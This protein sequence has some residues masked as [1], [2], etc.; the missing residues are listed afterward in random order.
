MGQYP[1]V[2]ECRPDI[3]AI[4]DAKDELTGFSRFQSTFLSQNGQS[5]VGTLGGATQVRRSDHMYG[6]D[7]AGAR[8]AEKD[9]RYSSEVACVTSFTH[10]SPFTACG[11]P[12]VVVASNATCSSSAAVRPSASPRRACEWTAP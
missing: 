3:A 7:L 2:A 11:Q 9:S 10:V 4:A 5:L 8:A 1:I 12:S 6:R